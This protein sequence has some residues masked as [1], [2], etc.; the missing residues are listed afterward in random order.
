[1]PA[2]NPEAWVHFMV[3]FEF[4][5]EPARQ[6]VPNVEAG[7]QEALFAGGVQLLGEVP[8]GALD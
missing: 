3:L 5:Q 1:M 7:L 4:L 6:T 2:K 8:A